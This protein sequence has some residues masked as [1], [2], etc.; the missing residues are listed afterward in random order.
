VIVEGVEQAIDV[1]GAWMA[2]MIAANREALARVMN[3]STSFSWRPQES[4]FLGRKRRKARDQ[5][6]DK[7]KKEED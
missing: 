1:S 3:V 6:K 7:N 5:D 4:Y 2:R